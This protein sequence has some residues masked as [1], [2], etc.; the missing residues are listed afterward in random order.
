MQ[1]HVWHDL[2]SELDSVFHTHVYK[3][4]YLNSQPSRHVYT[5]LAPTAGGSFFLPRLPH[6][7][8]TYLGL[9]GAR[10]TASDAVQL[11]LASHFVRRDV[12]MQLLGSLHKYGASADLFAAF[13]GSGSDSHPH[14]S[15]HDNEGLDMAIRSHEPPRAGADDKATGQGHV[16]S[17]MDHV[18]AVQRCFAKQHDTVPLIKEALRQEASSGGHHAEW[19][20]KTLTELNKCSPTAVAVSLEMLKRGAEMQ[21]AA[22]ACICYMRYVCLA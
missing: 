2:P 10:L 16:S 13:S 22:C 1:I 8:G 15:R 18:E 17:V 9:T 12:Q 11:G 6:N 7:L 19:A 5:G 21:V 3:H 4:A 14:S 20:L